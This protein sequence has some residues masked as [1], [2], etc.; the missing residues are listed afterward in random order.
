MV[1]SG[2][3]PWSNGTFPA[4]TEPVASYSNV[5]W[6]GNFGEYGYLTRL[7]AGAVSGLGGACLPM[8]AF[9]LLQGLET[10]GLYAWIA[11]VADALAVAR[12]LEAHPKVALRPL[13]SGPPPSHEHYERAKN[14]PKGPGAVFSFGEG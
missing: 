12:Y 14:L 6:C 13:R 5:T 4:M 3:F 10:L 8:N 7:R 1:E 2:R 9:L 11:Y